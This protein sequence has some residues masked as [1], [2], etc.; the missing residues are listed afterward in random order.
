MSQ[1]DCIYI[2]ASSLDARYTRIC[3]ASVRFFYPEIPIRLLVGGRLQRGLAEELHKYWGVGT[4]DL[5]LNGDYGWGFVKLEVLFGMPGERFLVLDSD[6]VLT[7][8]V[9]DVWNN[10]CAPF[11]VDDEALSEVRSN[12]IYYDWQKVRK[13]DQGAFPPRFVFNTGQWFGTAGLLTRNDFA[14]WI[15]WTMPRRTIPPGHFM[16]GEQGI[17][18]YVLNRKAALQGLLV[19]RKKIMR[20][21]GHS[22]ESLDAES[23]SKRIAPSLIIHWAGMKK[24]RLRH[25]A[26]SDILLYF[27]R[28]YY[29]RLPAGTLRRHLENCRHFLIDCQQWVGVRIKL[30]YRRGIETATAWRVSRRANRAVGT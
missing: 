27:E 16:N 4:A 2:A 25:M 3:V 5:P 10:S 26:G 14:P 29:S 23:V 12:T 30:C 11:V 21:P 28:L 13:I 19:A 18:N 8:P 6:T 24:T 15:E 17:L 7:G 20:W 9:L 22:L 1:V